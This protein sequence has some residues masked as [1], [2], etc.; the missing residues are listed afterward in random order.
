MVLRRDRS[1][2]LRLLLPQSGTH[3][4]IDQVKA[5]IVSG[6]IKTLPS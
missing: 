6:K 1:V 4:K 5:D 2:E 3:R